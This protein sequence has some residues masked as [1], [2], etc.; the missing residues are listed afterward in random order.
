MGTETDLKESARWFTSAQD[1]LDA[2]RLLL[3]GQ[4]FPLACFHAQQCAEKS[5]KA[6]LIASG[7]APKT[8][9]ISSLVKSLPPELLESQSILLKSVKLD[10]LYI[11]TRY[12]DALPGGAYARDLYDYEDAQNAIAVAEGCMKMLTIWAIGAGV[13]FDADPLQGSQQL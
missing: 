5:F 8:H 3:H 1:D 11:A 12:P 13:K 4:K 7:K 6:A 10:T 2:A 9:A